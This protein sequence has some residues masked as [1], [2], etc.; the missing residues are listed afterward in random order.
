MNIGCGAE[1]LVFKTAQ[2]IFTTNELETL[3]DYLVKSNM[4]IYEL[5]DR[6]RMRCKK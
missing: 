2:Y 1:H 5:I 4:T 6:D 3:S